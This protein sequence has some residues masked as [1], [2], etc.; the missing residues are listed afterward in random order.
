M[1]YYDFGMMSE[2][3]LPLKKGLCNLIF[4]IYANDPVEACD[5]ME[6][7]EVL[8]KTALRSMVE[9]VARDFLNDFTRTY[10]NSPMESVWENE[11]SLEEQ[12]A[13]KR[14]RRAQ[15]G[16]DVFSARSDLPFIL[17]PIYTFVFRAFTSLDGIGKGLD[18]NYDLSRLAQPYLR[19]LSDLKDGDSVL[20]TYAKKVAKDMGLQ[21]ASV[22]GLFDPKREK[23][24]A[25]SVDDK[26][27]LE[28]EKRQLE[29]SLAET[30]RCLER[31]KHQRQTMI[32]VLSFLGVQAAL[33]LLLK[34]IRLVVHP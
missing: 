12:R 1:V 13:I 2:L 16:M 28:E 30:R 31:V 20:V 4:A 23:Q 15:L 25:Q 6:H 24:Y 14:A 34:P 5:A 22:L 18:K 29:I 21:R 33:F 8:K 27:R 26:R 3:P 32:S 7:M 11:L 9:P 10:E 17:P 19:E